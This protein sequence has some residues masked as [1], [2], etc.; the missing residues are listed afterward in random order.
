LFAKAGA[1]G[2]PRYLDVLPQR[3][4]VVPARID[5]PGQ[6]VTLEIDSHPWSRTVVWGLNP[7]PAGQVQIRYLRLSD[8]PAGPWPWQV[9]G[10]SHFSNIHEPDAGRH[11]YPY[12]LGGDDVRP[13]SADVMLDYHRAGN[14]T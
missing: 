6:R 12:I 10:R 9:A 1:H 14:L 3:V 8:A 4:Y 5:E 11:N 13:P 7:P 2:D